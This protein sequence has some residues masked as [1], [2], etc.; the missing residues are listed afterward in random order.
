MDGLG[1]WVIH[2]VGLGWVRVELV[3]AEVKLVGLVG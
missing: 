2:W 3:G 1:S